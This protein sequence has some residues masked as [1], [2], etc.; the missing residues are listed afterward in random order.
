MKKLKLSDNVKNFL[1]LSLVKACL[2]RDDLEGLYQL[3]EDYSYYFGDHQEQTTVWEALVLAGV[4]LADAFKVLPED[5]LSESIYVK[6]LDLSGTTAI[7]IGK[8]F[9]ENSSITEVSIGDNIRTIGSQAF[10]D[11]P[12]LKTVV[13]GDNVQRI[14]SLAF[15]K[16]PKLERIYLPESVRFI[17]QDALKANDHCYILSPPRKP[18]TLHAKGDLAWLREHLGVDPR[19]REEAEAV[20]NEIE[21]E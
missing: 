19:Y 4:N 18:G 20:A 16:C 13:L 15:A 21:S 9:A 6:T 1:K 8:S 17:G 11:C 3:C 12:D 10:Y 7:S 14:E 2:Q 5:L